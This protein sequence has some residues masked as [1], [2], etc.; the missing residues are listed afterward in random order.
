M[1]SPISLVE[2]ITFPISGKVYDRKKGKKVAREVTCDQM[3]L[4]ILKNDFKDRCFLG[5]CDAIRILP[6]CGKM[7]WE[8]I[9]DAHP[10]LEAL[11]LENG[12]GKSQVAKNSHLIGFIGLTVRATL[13][14]KNKYLVVPKA[15]LGEFVVL[16]NAYGIKYTEEE[17]EFAEMGIQVNAKH[18]SDFQEMEILRRDFRYTH[19]LKNTEELLVYLTNKYNAK[20][21]RPLVELRKPEYDE[22]GNEIPRVKKSRAQKDD[23]EE[24]DSEGEA[25]EAP[26]ETV[27]AVEA[28]ETPVVVKK[29]KRTSKKE[30]SEPE[31]DT[32]TAPLVEKKKRAPRKPKQQQQEDKEKVDAAL[33]REAII[34]DRLK[35]IP[36]S[37]ISKFL[38]DMFDASTSVTGEVKSPKD[39]SQ[40]ELANFKAEMS[41][42]W[43]PENPVSNP[44]VNEDDE[45]SSSVEEIES[46]EDEE[47]EEEE[48]ND[49]IES[50]FD[51][52]ESSD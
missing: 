48:D 6:K 32:T 19:G 49:E 13:K 46:S 22:E 12:I 52:A 33:Q 30:K 35:N 1:N 14:K 23:S 40:A 3:T 50:Q 20:C 10:E 44:I 9:L 8:P 27:E 18:I 4:T 21:D 16:L 31:T 42:K 15:Y 26:E 38:I 11:T 47:D 2:K 34:R 25:S 43:K 29:R 17:K 36:E 51:P 45:S 5:P 37:E 41:K 24:E 28:N 39:M 7:L